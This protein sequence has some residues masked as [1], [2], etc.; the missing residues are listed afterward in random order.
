MTLTL[1]A[2]A[3]R[4]AVKE[5]GSAKLHASSSLLSS[6]ILVILLDT[7]SLGLDEWGIAIFLV[8][9]SF[10]IHENNLVNSI[11]ERIDFNTFEISFL[12]FPYH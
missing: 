1:E 12:P 4:V 3:C 9:C 7:P 2:A 5:F 10:F 8:M 11:D 6:S